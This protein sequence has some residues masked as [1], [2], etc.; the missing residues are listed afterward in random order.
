MPGR[1]A[2][3]LGK[4]QDKTIKDLLSYRI[5]RLANTLS[6]GAARRYKAEFEVSLMEWRMLALLGDFAP[7]TLKQLALESGLDKSLASRAISELV[8]RRLVLRTPGTDDAREVSLRLSE[9]G[10]RVYEGLMRS[11]RARDAAFNAALS[12]AELATLDSLLEKLM[13]VARQQAQPEAWDTGQDKPRR[14]P[15]RAAKVAP[16]VE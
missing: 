5:H 9:S 8:K 6:Q 10:R 15:T 12:P 1:S 11:A 14:A 7:M 13:R 4:P 16:E 2:R 3:P